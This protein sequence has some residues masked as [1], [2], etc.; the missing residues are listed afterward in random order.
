MM[1]ENVMVSIL[2][3]EDGEKYNVTFRSKDH[4]DVSRIAISF[5]GGGHKNACGFKI[6]KKEIDLE[7]LKRSVV[8]E[9]K[10]IL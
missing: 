2:I 9:V 6:S 1:I 8:A 4:I 7:T 5:G 3:K 10:K